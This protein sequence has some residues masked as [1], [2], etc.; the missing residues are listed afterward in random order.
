MK[1]KKLI[2]KESKR[3]Y[4]DKVK[5]IKEIL[6]NRKYLEKFKQITLNNHDE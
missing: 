4:N 3:A 2:K 5:S 1:K 6:R